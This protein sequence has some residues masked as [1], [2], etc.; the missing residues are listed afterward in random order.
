M[1]NIDTR[2]TNFEDRYGN[3]SRETVLEMLVG[4]S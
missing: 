3:R 4:I 2:T 1:K